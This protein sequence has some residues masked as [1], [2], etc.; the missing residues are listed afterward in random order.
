MTTDV[1]HD[2]TEEEVHSKVDEIVKKSKGT[3]FTYFSMSN[4]DRFNSF[5]KAAVDNN[6]ILVID[7]NFARIMTA[8][9]DILPYPDPLNDPNIKVYFRYAKSC[10]F[11][12]NDY[13]PKERLYCHNMITF[14]EIMKEPDKYLMHIGFFKL[15]ELIYLQPSNADFIYSMSEHF[16]EGEENKD[17]RV[18]WENWMKHFDIS[19][20]KVHCSGHMSKQEVLDMVKTIDAEV[21]IPIHTQNAAEFKKEHRNVKVVGNGDSFEF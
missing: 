16:L 9:K 11:N 10:T 21:V 14:K 6:R 15:M 7:T 2:Y 17:Q 3:V 4:V 20:H 19:F 1:E 8:L 13:T 12:E 5:Y 18:I